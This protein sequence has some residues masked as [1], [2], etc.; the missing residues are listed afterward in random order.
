VFFVLSPLTWNDKAIFAH[1]RNFI[2]ILHEG[3][4]MISKILLVLPRSILRPVEELFAKLQEDRMCWFC[5]VE[6]RV[7][8][9]SSFLLVVLWFFLELS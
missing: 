5:T 1:V 4:C 3:A 7:H 8:L 6:Y 2:G 9:L